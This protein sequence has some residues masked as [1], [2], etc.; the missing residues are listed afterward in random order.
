MVALKIR[1]HKS[2]MLILTYAHLKSYSIYDTLHALLSLNSLFKVL[3]T[4][5]FP[6]GTCPLSVSSQS[7]SLGSGIYASAIQY[8]CITHN[9]LSLYNY[10]GD[11]SDST[12]VLQLQM[13]FSQATSAL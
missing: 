3:F 4:F 5:N 8:V 12:F 13:P 6:H 11:T 2:Y 7:S 10:I 9:S 1:S